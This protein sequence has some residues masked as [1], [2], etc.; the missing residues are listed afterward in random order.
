MFTKQNIRASGYSFPRRLSPKNS[1][2]VSL[3]T[4]SF[5]PF[6]FS[7]DRYLELK[8]GVAGYDFL[9]AEIGMK[10]EI[11]KTVSIQGS[12]ALQLVF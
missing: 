5:L 2:V 10:K 9:T 1:P 3:H 12:S 6:M 7:L 4:S 11:L 8:M